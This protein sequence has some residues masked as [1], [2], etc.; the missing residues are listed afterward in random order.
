MTD[1][2][3][4]AALKAGWT[5][6]NGKWRN[7]ANDD[8]S[9]YCDTPRAFRYICE[10]HNIEARAAPGDGTHV[11]HFYD[12]STA[13]ISPAAR[14]WLEAQAHIAA[15][16]FEGDHRVAAFATGWVM[17]VP[18]PQPQEGDH[19]V[20]MPARIH[21]DLHPACFEAFAANCS[22]IMFDADAGESETLPV[23]S[24]DGENDGDGLTDEEKAAMALAGKEAEADEGGLHDELEGAHAIHPEDGMPMEPMPADPGDGVAHSPWCEPADAIAQKVA[25]RMVARATADAYGGDITAYLTASMAQKI[26]AEMEAAG[27]PTDEEIMT[28]PG[29]GLPLGVLNYWIDTQQMPPNAYNIVHGVPVLTGT[30]ILAL[31]RRANVDEGLVQLIGN[32]LSEGTRAKFDRFNDERM[33]RVDAATMGQKITELKAASSDVIAIMRE[34]AGRDFPVIATAAARLEKALAALDA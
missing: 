11:R 7:P 16:G 19:K 13:H 25:E 27:M 22:Y 17:W 4:E 6:I 9:A 31:L 26:T 15:T 21:A 29:S 8:G 32:R 1:Y 10:D 5:L 20:F 33:R 12:L 34:V 28:G 14:Q 2:Y 23:Y 30:G 24:W 3:K 18:E